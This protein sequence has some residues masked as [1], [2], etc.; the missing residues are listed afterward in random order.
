MKFS[1]NW[2]RTFVNPEVTSEQLAHALTM[3]G[4]EVEALESL[5]PDFNNVVIGEVLSLEKHPDADRLQVC[6]VNVGADAPLQIVCGAKNVHVGAR[7]PCAQVGAVLPGIVIKQAKVRG[8]ESS[9][10]LCSEK[11]IGLAEES[12]GLLLLPADAP[13]GQ[14]I[15]E[16]L[17]LNDKLFTLKLTPN[18]GDCLSVTGVAREVSAVTASSLVL[19]EVTPAAI[20][21]SAGMLAVNV[22]D[23]KACPRYCGRIV[24]GVN[25][26]V[27]TPAWMMRRLERSGL[28]SIN[29]IVDVTNYVLLELGQP[30]HAFDLNKLNGGITVRFATQDEQLTLLNEQ[31]VKLA[32]DMLVIADDAKALALAG[33]MG[34]LDS[35]VSDTTT[36]IFLESAFFSPAVIAGK[37]RSFAISSDSSFRFERGVDF[38]STRTSLERATCLIQ[39]ICGGVAGEIT[40]V[41]GELPKRDPIQLRV[42]RAKRV[43]GINLQED[44]V[45]ALLRLQQLTFVSDRDVYFVTPP[46]YRFDLNIEAD[47]IEELV[48][49][50]GYDNV[51]AISPRAN[52]GMLPKSESVREDSELRQVLVNRDYQEVINYSFVDETWEKDFAGNAKPIKLQNPIASHMSTMRSTLFGGLIDGLRFNLNRKQERVRLFELGRCFVGDQPSS[53]QQPLRIA[54]LCYGSVRSE[55]W[56]ESARNVDYYDMKADVEALCWPEIPRFVAAQHPA[57]HPGQSATVWID[58]KSIGWLGVL[59]PQWQQKYDLPQSATLFELDLASLQK[60]VV[61]V[62][63]EYSKLQQV[64][65]DIAVVVDE[66]L[67]VQTILDALLENKPAIVTAVELFDVYRGKGI[68]SDKKSLA[69]RVLM[70][71]TQKTLTDKETDEAISHLTQ[72]LN[73]RFNAKL[74]T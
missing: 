66:S 48:R 55:Q 73:N 67:S 49:L 39:E 19:P 5:V 68:D 64:R 61:P 27:P 34:G 24:R 35:A 17:D 18:R 53:D 51:K 42:A 69:F 11:E 25:L 32:G 50:Y 23:A 37:S 40:E 41:T 65:R 29:A 9:G 62:F 30:L 57:L 56:G 12:D 38:A 1:E 6:K 14:N 22:L 59:H 70:Q 15:R 31:A 26:A 33:I 43:L 28:R 72:I 13:V 10:M 7:V 8:V 47:L 3:S 54:G 52:L 36:D 60:R 74:R 20:D 45:E 58:G 44:Q 16:Y 71:D 4:L 2:L 63:S 21:K 46:S